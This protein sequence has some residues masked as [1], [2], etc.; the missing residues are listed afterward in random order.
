MNRNMNTGEDQDQRWTKLWPAAG[1]ESVAHCPVCGESDREILYPDLVDNVF[2]A[3]PGRWSLWKCAKCSS[4]YLDPRPSPDTIHLA[5][6]NYFTHQVAAAKDDYASLSPFRKL[7][8]RLVNGYTNWR[9][10]TNAIPSSAF[11]LLAAFAMPNLKRILDREYRHMPRLPKGGGRLLD[12]GCGDGS[13]LRLAHSCGWDVVGLD[14]DPKAAA[15]A[16]KQGL[17]VHQGGIEYFEGKTGLFDVITL[18]HVIE[19][20]Y[21]PVK[22]L[23]TSHALLKAGGQL[24]LETPNIDSLGHAR[25]QQNWRGLETPRHLVLFNRQSLGQAFISAGCPAPHDRAHPSPCAEMFKASFAMEHG[26]SPYE[27]LATPKALQL[28]VAIAAFVETL[29]PP[30]R[31]F[32]TVTTRKAEK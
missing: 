31:E 19:H 28:R 9:Y 6:A 30:R 5:Y 16:A 3:A 1:L 29:W 8:R 2:R 10:G 20:V 17:T 11:G 26:R 14:P 4:A 15:N 7:R 23:E 25:F 24:W 27:S 22:V 13:F 32:L 18:N 21:E 12:V